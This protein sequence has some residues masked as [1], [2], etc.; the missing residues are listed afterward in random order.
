MRSSVWCKVVIESV[1]FSNA[2][3]LALL[4]ARITLSMRNVLQGGLLYFVSVIRASK[5]LLFR[6][7]GHIAQNIHAVVL[8]R[9][10]RFS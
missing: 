3:T 7:H 5:G 8:R 9:R 1:V 2:G 4:S 10:L 6:L